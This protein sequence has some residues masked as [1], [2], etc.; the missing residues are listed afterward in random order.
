[1]SPAAPLRPLAHKYTMRI[2]FAG[3][4]HEALTFSPIHATAKD[5][6]VWRGQEVLEYP[7]VSSLRQ[8]P[9]I[10]VVPVLI[11][12]SPVPSGIVERS[13]YLGFRNA[14]LDGIASAGHLDAVCLVLHGALLV[15]EIWSGE[16]DLVREIRG[17]VGRDVLI[18]ARLDLHANL[19]EEFANKANL[20]AGYRTAPHRDIDATLVRTVS[21]LARCVRDGIRPRPA[22]IHLPLLLQGEKSTTGVEPMRS[23]L[24]TTT[25]IERMPGILNAE[26]LVGF[27]W[28]DAAHSGSSVT[29]V[30][31]GE[32]HLP[33]ARAQAK[34]LA[35]AMWQQRRNFAVVQENVASADQAIDLALRAQESSVFISDCGDN[36]S[37]GATG[38]VTHFLSR[39]LAKNV[40]DAVL[41]GMAD[42]LAYRACA[43]AGIGAT[44]T[45]S[46]GGKFDTL[47]GDPVTVTGVVEHLYQPQAH[48][49]DSAAVVAPLGQATGERHKSR[50]TGIATL[51][52]GGIRVLVTS[53]RKMFPLHDDFRRAGIEPLE[54]KLVVVKMGYLFPELRDIAPREILAFTPGCADMDLKRLP[55]RYVTRPIFPLDPDLEWRP[56]ISNV[57]G[58]TD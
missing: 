15:E 2:A 5:F 50:E 26:L 21:L 52:V 31:S 55:Y 1:V 58:Y 4:A 43:E 46:L 42:G 47:H 35:Q 6:R 16:T 29:V 30:A 40:P 56:S 12:E 10:E 45:V 51:R 49:E 13:T 7:A 53:E 57:A 11:A 14:I 48:S 18:G 20:W 17:L 44:V 25:E 24:T 39:L 32:E 8:W 28:A 38:D 19:T 22:F 3:I 23:L 33:A 36:P 54:H 34:R 27:G 37:A 9:D 41:A